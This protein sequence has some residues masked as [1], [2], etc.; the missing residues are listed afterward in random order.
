M[1]H[2]SEQIT[3]SVTQANVKVLGDWQKQMADGFYQ[4]MEI[5]IQNNMAAQ[6]LAQDTLTMASGFYK[7]YYETVNG[8]TQHSWAA[9]S[10]VWSDAWGVL[11]SMVDAASGK[12]KSK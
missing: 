1:A 11:G 4:A 9:Y 2:V 12:P 6:Q 5:G 3:D 7:S 10:P 8:M